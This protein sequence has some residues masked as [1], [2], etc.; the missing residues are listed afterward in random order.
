MDWTLSWVQAYKDKQEEI[1]VLQGLPVYP[2][3][4]WGVQ[5]GESHDTGLD[6]VS[7]GPWGM[8]DQ[9]WLVRLGKAHGEGDIWIGSWK[10]ISILPVLTL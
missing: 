5:G 3:E 10:M 1:F 6:G 4:R 7:L 9:L 8:C 2:W